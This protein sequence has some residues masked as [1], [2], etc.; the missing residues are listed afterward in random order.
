[1]YLLRIKKAGSKAKNATFNLLPIDIDTQVIAMFTK[2]NALKFLT[3]YH[4]F[5]KSFFRDISYFF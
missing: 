4:Q 1:M 2:L 3:Y 5:I